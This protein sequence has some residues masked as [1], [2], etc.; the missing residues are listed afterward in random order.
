MLYASLTNRSV[1]LAHSCLNR[2]KADFLLRRGRFRP[3]LARRA[4]A[5]LSTGGDR[6]THG[7]VL[8]AD[9]GVHVAI[10]DGARRPGM[11]TRAPTTARFPACAR[12]PSTSYCWRSSDPQP[13]PRR[14]ASPP[15]TPTAAGT[16]RSSCRQW[17][18]PGAGS[19]SCRARSD[20]RCRWCGSGV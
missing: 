5:F 17:S 11:S 16:R 18:G 3:A 15:C 8:Q 10:V 12:M 7:H 13:S 20:P 14:P 19:P 6:G 2:N 1:R 9:R 4:R